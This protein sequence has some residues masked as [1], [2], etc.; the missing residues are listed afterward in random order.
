MNHTKGILSTLSQH[1]KL[2]ISVRSN[3][4]HNLSAEVMQRLVQPHQMDFYFFAFIDSGTATYGVDLDEIVLTDGQI[5]FVRPHQV[6]TPPATIDPGLIFYKLAFDDQ[7]L[8][9]LPQ[10]YAFLAQPLNTQVMD[11]DEPARQRIKA[12][13]DILTRLLHTD[14]HLRETNMVLVYLHTLLAEFNSAYF[15]QNGEETTGNSRLSK[16]IEFQVVVESHLTE[17]PSVQTIADQLA[18]STNGLYALVKA[19]A[20][21]S[22]KEFI[23][24][25]LMLEA[26]RRLHYTSPS[27]KELA[28]ELGF[29]DPDY[30]SRLFKKSTGKSVSQFLEHRRDLSGT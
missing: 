2:P 18:L 13:F 22:P 21:V 19:F 20:G 6:L 8:A 10:Q 9:L 15:R 30:F 26:Q 16:Y 27:V 23:T 14:Q 7:A 28:Y 11:T 24:H 1:E 3:Q 5:L 25:R 29:N 12:V 17:Q 4:H